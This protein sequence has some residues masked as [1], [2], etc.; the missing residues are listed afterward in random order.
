VNLP[1][2]HE[3]FLALFGQYNRDLWPALVV[4]WIAT[5][6]AVGKLYLRTGH[7]SR[8]IAGLLAIHWAWSGAVYHL[9]Y[10][11]RI[12][13]AALLFGLVFLLEAGL[14]LCFGVIT[15]HLTFDPHGARWR[16]VAGALILYSLTYPAIGL[17]FGLRTHRLPGFG[18][19][20][21][22]TLLTA[23]LLLLLPR[24]EAQVLGVIPVLWAAVGGSAAFALQ[25]RAD[26][27][28]PPAGVVLL[29]YLVTRSP[30]SPGA[31]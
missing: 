24:R 6:V 14:F 16:I 8:A 15:S 12:N 23:G 31:T 18:V 2:S 10:F 17:A 21:P 3:Q 19:P 1:F 26:L 25:I 20:C 13:P 22:T 27:A 5:I 30:I 28:L 11:R 7:R 29:A 9:F 4:L